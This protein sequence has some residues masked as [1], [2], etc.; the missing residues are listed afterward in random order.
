M[1]LGICA[2]V[3]PMDVEGA[4]AFAK[5]NEFANISIEFDYAACKEDRAAWCKK[6]CALVKE[7]DMPVSILAL[8]VLCDIGMSLAE[9]EEEV[10]VPQVDLLI[11][12]ENSDE[13][14]EDVHEAVFP[15]PLRTLP[16]PMR[17]THWLQ[18]LKRML[19]I[20]A[21]RSSTVSLLKTSV[22]RT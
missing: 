1:K 21:R 15:S 20:S 5:E 6:I 13:E 11:P 22:T 8:N 10:S 4:F 9:K 12:R 16:F 7:Y 14:Q 18:S 17:N 2:W 19:R 3:L